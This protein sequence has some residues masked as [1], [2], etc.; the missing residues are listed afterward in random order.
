M[1]YRRNSGSERDHDQSRTTQQKGRAKCPQLLVLPLPCLISS[2][3]PKG[4]Y[5]DH[6]Q[7]LALE[8]LFSVGF[9]R[10]QMKTFSQM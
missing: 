7:K 10:C 9:W 8:S 2:F 6:F 4:D 1:F 3:S 5:W